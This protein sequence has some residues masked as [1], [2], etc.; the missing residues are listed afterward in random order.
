MSNKKLVSL[1]GLQSL[2]EKLKSIFVL[3]DEERLLTIKA[4]DG[5]TYKLS[6]D[7]NLRLILEEHVKARQVLYL[8][9]GD[10]FYYLSEDESGIYLSKYDGTPAPEECGYITALSKDTGMKFVVGVENEQVVFNLATE[11]NSDISEAK[12]IK[13]N[14]KLYYFQIED[15]DVKIYYEYETL[16]TNNLPLK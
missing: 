12:F 4:P 2:I 6:L 10:D 1:N 3:K 16:T 15:D 7:A 14:D 11:Q 8:V 5:N 13:C 9:S